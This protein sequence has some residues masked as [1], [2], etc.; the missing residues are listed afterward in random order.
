MAQKMKKLFLLTP[1]DIKR[2]RKL[3]RHL[4]R[5]LC[6]LVEIKRVTTFDDQ[7]RHYSPGECDLIEESA[8]VEYQLEFQLKDNSDF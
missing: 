5:A 8:F 2:M 7:R 6:E 3:V 4:D 1:A